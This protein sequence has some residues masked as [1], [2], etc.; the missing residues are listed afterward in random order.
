MNDNIKRLE[1][2]RK[3]L[4]LSKFIFS[5]KIGIRATNYSNIINGRTPLKMSHIYQLV[6]LGFNPLWVLNGE[7]ECKL[8]TSSTYLVPESTTI[9]NEPSA[10]FLTEAWLTEGVMKEINMPLFKGEF[11]Y[12]L[13]LSICKQYIRNHSGDDPKSVNFPALSAAFLASLQAWDLLIDSLLRS[14]HQDKVEFE[15]L[16]KQYTFS[17]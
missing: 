7:G 12:A 2:V 13:L 16:G 1:E 11:S 8:N 10:K 5:E 17:L 6:N 14:G 9:A 15:M 4:N 3:T